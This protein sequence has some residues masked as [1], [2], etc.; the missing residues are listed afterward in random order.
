MKLLILLLAMAA[1]ALAEPPRL[2]LYTARAEGSLTIG[3]DGRVLEVAL[4][5]EAEL[6]DGV[7]AGFEQRIR[8]WRFEPII[9]DGKPVNV[10]GTMYL[11]LVAAQEV[12]SATVTY[13]IRHVQFLD[14][15]GASSDPRGMSRM[16][17][18]KY[19]TDAVRVGVGADVGL[20]VKV[21]EGGQV[22]AVTAERLALLGI[23]SRQPRQERLARQFRE[24]AEGVA[25]KWVFAGHAPGEVVRVPIRYTSAKRG[26]API[27]WIQTVPQ[28]IELPEWAQIQR[29]AEEAT[30]LS[31]TGVALSTQIRLLTPL[32]GA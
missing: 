6:G 22:E 21:G 1:P 7:L 31:A 2:D 26:S 13:G 32:D 3:T 28:H 5:S 30:D 17:Q 8:A 15:P 12:G 19:P 14:P 29:V 16:V 18:P 4:T 10:K 23:S 27:G 25:R 20:L 24:S 11:G 9:E